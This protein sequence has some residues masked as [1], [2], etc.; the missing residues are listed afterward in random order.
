MCENTL[1]HALAKMFGKSISKK[2]Y[3]NLL[4]PR[5]I[6]HFTIHDLRRTC[7]SL[8]AEL[9]IGNDIAERCLNHKIKG[10]AGVY[11][12]YDYLEERRSALSTLADLVIPLTNDH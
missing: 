7:R 1:N 9:G 5:G 11:N 12:R 4:E 2:S 10:V 8:L 6:K 3:P